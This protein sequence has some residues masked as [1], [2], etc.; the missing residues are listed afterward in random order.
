MQDD[1]VVQQGADARLD[2]EHTDE[3]RRRRVLGQDALDDERA[4]ESLDPERD[5]P[6][7]L[8]HAAGRDLL[9]K[10][11]A[12]EPLEAWVGRAQPRGR[13]REGHRTALHADRISSTD[14]L[15]RVSWN[16]NNSIY[17][18]GKRKVNYNSQRGC[19]HRAL[20][21]RD[22]FAPV[23]KRDDMSAIPVER[24]PGSDELSGARDIRTLNSFL[25]SIIEHIPAMVFV[26]DAATLRYE[27][28]N[29]A[30]EDLTGRS[31]DAMLGQGRDFALFP[32]EEARFF[33][34]KDRRGAS[35]TAASSTSPR[36][37]SRRPMACAGC[38]RRRSRSSRRRASRATCSASRRT[39]PIAR[40]PTSGGSRRIG[41][42]SDA[43]TNARRS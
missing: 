2:A 33:H 43:S 42:S 20:G 8:S 1:R 25:D 3:L 40:R 19:R 35:R 23:T 16:M 13:G 4:P 34:E 24:A 30:G 29:R 41:S 21:D 27:R 32:A 37:R 12:P 17:L 5:R 11:V 38:T 22:W 6:I 10:E 36:S 28:F 14:R 7:D 39:S 9:Q 18:H 26:K 15:W 31:R